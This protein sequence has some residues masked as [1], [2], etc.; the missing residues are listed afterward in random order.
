VGV[1]RHD[2][3]AMK[4]FCGYHFADYW[5]H[6]LS[7]DKEGAN[8]PAVFTVNW[9]RKDENGKF[10]WP[11]F[12]DNM[13]VLE[14]IVKRVSGKADAQSTALGD[15]PKVEDFNLEGLESFNADDLTALLAVNS[16]GWKNEIANT[17]EYLETFGERVPDALYKELEKTQSKL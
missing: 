17:K 2:P 5:S 14:W 12:G 8:L 15:M 7:F 13:R 16:E 9:F 3:M 11:G 6:W 4:P 1:V 10:M